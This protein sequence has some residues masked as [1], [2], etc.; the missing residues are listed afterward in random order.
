[1]STIQPQLLTAV[2]ETAAA[3]LLDDPAYCAQ[4]KFDGQRLIIKICHG[5]ATGYNRLGV[6]VD[7]PDGLLLPDCDCLLD[8]ERV[9]ETYHPFDLLSLGKIDLRGLPYA[10]RYRC[11]ECICQPVYTAWTAAEKAALYASLRAAGR[12]GIVFKRLDAPYTAGRSAAQLKLKFVT[13][14]TCLVIGHNPGRSVALAVQDA[15]GLVQIGNVTIPASQPTPP[16][17][18]LVEVRYL[19]AVRQLVQP[20]YV[21]IRDDLTGPDTRASLKMRAD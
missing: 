9:G 14:A 7:L 12:E 20:V 19:Y 13:T 10:D 4:E 16:V 6:E 8:G 1:M 18:S 11:L 17:N 15:G 5:Q 2:P 21:S 3:G